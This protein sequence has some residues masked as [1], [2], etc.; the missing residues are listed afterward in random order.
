V[1][2]KSGVEEGEK[3][4]CVPLYFCSPLNSKI[5]GSVTSFLYTLIVHTAKGSADGNS[6]IVHA[7]AIDL[8]VVLIYDL[9]IFC[10]N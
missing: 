9:I 6:I 5:V 3:E 7:Q 4:Q 2:G 1:C 8:D 10:I